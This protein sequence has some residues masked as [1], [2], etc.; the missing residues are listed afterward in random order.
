MEHPNDYFTREM[1]LA[2]LACYETAN[3]NGI[4]PEQADKCEGGLCA[5][6]PFV[7]ANSGGG[8]GLSHNARERSRVT[9][10]G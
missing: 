3:R 1:D 10:G 6:C 7:P 5:D 8:L 4:D 9:R 2:E